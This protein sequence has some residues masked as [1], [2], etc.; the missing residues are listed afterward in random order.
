MTRSIFLIQLM[1]VVL[2]LGRVTVTISYAAEP[3]E[4]GAAGVSRPK[5]GSVAA[6]AE[7]TNWW[8]FRPLT[9]PAVPV[10]EELER[11]RSSNS[12]PIDAFI[13]AKLKEKRLRP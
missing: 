9:R 10:V 11:E 7:D 13:R 8:A 2:C 3:G 1:A 6:R 4:G 12:N 5:G